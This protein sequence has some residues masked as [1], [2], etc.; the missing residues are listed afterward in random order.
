MHLNHKTNWNGAIPFKPLFAA[1]GHVRDAYSAKPSNDLTTDIRLNWETL[2]ICALYLWSA[3]LIH[4][5]SYASWFYSI[6]LTW[7]K[8]IA[9]S[10][11][12]PRD[13]SRSRRVPTQ[14]AKHKAHGKMSRMAYQT[15]DVDSIMTPARDDKQE[16]TTF[17]MYGICYEKKGHW[18]N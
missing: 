15:G 1:C 4:R 7:Q 11:T 14:P 6:L 17:Y 12:L 16:L 18:L 9:I 13:L 5:A 8:I 10:C 2:C 3:A